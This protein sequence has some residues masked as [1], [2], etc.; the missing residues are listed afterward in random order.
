MTLPTFGR[1]PAA[2]S[3]TVP[4]IVTS[5]IAGRDHWRA[6]RK[7][8]RA[9]VVRMALVRMFISFSFRFPLPLAGEGQGEGGAPREVRSGERWSALGVHP[10]RLASLGSLSR[11]RARRWFAA[12]TDGD[13][14]CRSNEAA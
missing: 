9:K 2:I 11:K 4:V 13:E 10:H 8:T 12:L 5:A 1:G 14:T 7:A 6:S 3:P